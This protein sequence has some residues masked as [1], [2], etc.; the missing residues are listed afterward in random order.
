MARGERFLI[1]SA[2]VYCFRDELA[3]K[4]EWYCIET[5]LFND[6]IY[7]SCKWE[8]EVDRFFNLPS[9]HYR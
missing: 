2:G 4:A 6:G 8:L 7:W 9:Q 3:E 5:N 1:G